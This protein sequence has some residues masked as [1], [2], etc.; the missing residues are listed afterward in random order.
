MKKSVCFIILFPSLFAILYS[1][2]LAIDNATL[3]NVSYC[4][5]IYSA[6]YDRSIKKY[7]KN[8]RTTEYILKM[9]SMNDSLV[10]FSNWALLNDSIY[11]SDVLNDAEI[12][13]AVGVCDSILKAVP[14]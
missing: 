7:M 3:I 13:I 14:S 8:H 4:S 10:S 1:G 11:R 12:D 5:G 6:S 9:I 2:A